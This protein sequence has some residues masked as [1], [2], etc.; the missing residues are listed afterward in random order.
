MRSRQF[1]DA[2]EKLTEAIREAEAVVETMRTEHDPLASHIFVSRRHYQNLADTKSGKPRAMSAQLSWQTACELGFC[3]HLDE[4]ERL[5]L[6]RAGKTARQVDG[7]DRQ[8]HLADRPVT[9]PAH[10]L[11]DV[12]LREHGQVRGHTGLRFEGGETMTK[13][14][15]DSLSQII[16]LT[17]ADISAV[18]L[19]LPENLSA[20]RP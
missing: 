3:G 18:S 15:E 12:A 5:A 19:E 6:L 1:H 9:R 20:R 8:Y 7:A 10:S 11:S 4:W 13:R 16:P 2:L 17:G 14:L